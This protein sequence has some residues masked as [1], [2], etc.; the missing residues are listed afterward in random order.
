MARKA[1]TFITNHGA[2]LALIG[3][4]RQITTREIAS[5][6]DITERSVLR[7]IRDLEADGYIRIAKNGRR[8]TYAVNRDSPLRRSDQRDIAVGKLLEILT[9]PL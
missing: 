9:A 8:N 1:W 7:I 2:V 4:R 5:Q 6:L 3:E